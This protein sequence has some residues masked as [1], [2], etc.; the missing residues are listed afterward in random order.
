MFY[1]LKSKMMLTF[2]LL[3]VVPFLTMV[4]IFTEQSKKSVELITKSSSAQTLE[5]YAGYLDMLGGQVEDIAFQVL[6]NQLIQ[7][8][9]EVRSG[10]NDSLT[11]TERYVLNA[12]VKNF[13]AHVI[14]SQSNVASI[15][16]H[17]SRGFVIG[18]DS[19]YE[20]VTYASEDWYA[21]VKEHGV[22]WLGSHTDPYQPHALRKEPINSLL[23]PLVELKTLTVQGAMK[24]N[25]AS[26]L[27]NQP[28]SKMEL[29]EWRTVQLVNRS[30]IIA[31]EAGESLADEKLP[32]EDAQWE[33]IANSGKQKDVVKLKN[34]DGT[35]SYWFYRNLDVQDW[36]IVGEVTE[37]TLFREINTTSRTMLLIGVGL[38][39]LTIGAAYWISTGMTRPLTKLSQMMRRLEMGDFN[40]A[41]KLDTSKK[42][43]TGYLLHVFA[44][45]AGQLNQLI[46]NEFTLKLRKQDA[47]YKALLMQVNPHF[48]YNTLEVIGGLAAQNKTEQLID[49][50]ESLGQMLRHSLKLDTDMITV[51]AEMQQLRYYISIMESRF[52][53]EISFEIEQD[54]SLGQVYMIR[55]ILQPLVENAVKYSKERMRRATIRIS[56]LRSA[57]EELMLTV[58]DNGEG[59]S[60]QQVNEI[61]GAALSQ[62]PSAVL[63]GPGRRIGL[64]NVLVRCR[65]YYG[66]RFKVEIDSK[67]GQGTKIK[68]K[69]PISEE[70][71]HVQNIAGG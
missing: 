58:E 24:V 48:L 57:E 43:E 28:L 53:D 70:M 13:I 30:G 10:T 5:Q 39:L 22:S 38:L 9:I 32:M 2:S 14:L 63:G 7:E 8:W 69:L 35:V 16:L 20:H 52:D 23:F 27:I 61:V 50:T 60:E 68:I 3:L 33:Q 62:D 11:L 29:N 37:K 31:T 34:A 56:A 36:I 21:Y 49:V 18:N 6:G 15:S 1:S 46:R 47:E 55:F 65:L 59:M 66:E 51:S 4:L 19:V 41:E 26:S 40:V 67:A 25:I 12:E 42:G 71:E 44:R 54:P 64:R 17:D 45:M